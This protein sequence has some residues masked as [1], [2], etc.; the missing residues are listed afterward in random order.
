VLSGDK[1]VDPRISKQCFYSAAPEIE[2]CGDLTSTS[3]SVKP[4]LFINAILIVREIFIIRR[5]IAML[6]AF[7][8]KINKNI[9]YVFYQY[10]EVKS[11]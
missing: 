2:K 4:S 5:L 9:I 7:P 10:S 3:K 11:I 8:V 1:I 6:N